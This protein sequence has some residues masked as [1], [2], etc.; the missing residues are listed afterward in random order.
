MRLDC[1]EKID[2]KH[3]IPME[4]IRLKYGVD[5]NAMSFY[6]CYIWQNYFKHQLYMTDDMYVV[7]YGLKGD[8][9]WYF[10]VGESSE[11]LEFI[12]KIINK[13]DTSFHKLNDNDKCFL[14]VN[15]PDKFVFTECHG[16]S[17]YIC[18]IS[19]TC[20]MKGN[21]FSKLRSKYNNVVKQYKIKIEPIS[22]RVLPMAFEV[23]KS[24]GSNKSSSGTMGII[25]NEVD[26]DTLKKYNE[27]EL[28]G[29]IIWLNDRIVSVVAGYQLMPNMID[30]AICKS[31][32]DI[33][34]MGYVSFVEL[35]RYLSE[36]YQYANL[37]EDLGI[38][39]LR[40]MK[41]NMGTCR[42]LTLWE[43]ACI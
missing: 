26:I 20:A 25:G 4:S 38:P 5:T 17:E 33:K 35:M 8:N 11:K 23:I 3:K 1:L 10:P 14:E 15:F 28:K 37:E 21:R 19:E 12:N 9:A 34:Y 22:E 13:K 36:K 7:T 31:L 29:I 18:D 43:A 27:L 24:W 41:N 30:I 6:S 16:D 42:K 39:G 2:I 32:K 40:I